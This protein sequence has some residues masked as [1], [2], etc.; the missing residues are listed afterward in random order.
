MHH[1][2]HDVKTPVLQAGTD[3]LWALIGHGATALP[4]GLTPDLFL[5]CE[6][7]TP[8]MSEISE[9]ASIDA[10]K[11]LKP[12]SKEQLQEHPEL[13]YKGKKGVVLPPLLTKILMDAD[14]ED[15]FILLRACSRHY[16]T[17]MR[18]LPRWWRTRRTPRMMTTRRSWHQLPSFVWCSSFSLRRLTRRKFTATWTR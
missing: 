18:P 17:S 6:G 8:T 3:E 11:K 16:W 5:G 13:Q 1:F 14:S 2:H 10:L 9:A 15:P 7:I 4:V 12:A